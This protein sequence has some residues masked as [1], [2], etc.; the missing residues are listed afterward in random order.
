MG[1][2]TRWN[3]WNRRLLSPGDRHDAHLVGTVHL[4][5]QDAHDHETFCGFHWSGNR[6]EDTEDNVTCEWCLEAAEQARKILGVR[7][8]R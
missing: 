5:G 4:P 7:S 6:Y 3:R 8:R 2:P 1:D